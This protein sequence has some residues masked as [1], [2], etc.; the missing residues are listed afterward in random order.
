MDK[1]LF[2]L[3]IVSS[4]FTS[5]L[6]FYSILNELN[7]Y[8]GQRELVAEEMALKVYNELMRYSQDLKAER[9]HVSTRWGWSWSPMCRWTPARCSLFSE[10]R[11]TS[12]RSH[13][14][15]FSCI[16]FLFGFT[17]DQCWKWCYHVS[18]MPATI[19][20]WQRKNV[21]IHRFRKNQARLFFYQIYGER[22]CW[23][24]AEKHIYKFPVY[25]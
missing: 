12:R 23:E 15:S 3:V 11:F 4:R 25:E 19:C 21:S 2:I 24:T 10:N 14:S 17:E 7:D 8:A 22:F 6:S 13:P 1:V 9:K 18:L 5:C 20:C 16:C